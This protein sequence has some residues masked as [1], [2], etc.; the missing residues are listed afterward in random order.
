MLDEVVANC[1]PAQVEI[2][3]H[4]W[5][6]R[7]ASGVTRRANSTLVLGDVDDRVRALRSASDFHT[8][9]DSPTRLLVSDASAPAWVRPHLEREGFRPD[10]ETLMLTGPVQPAAPSGRWRVEADDEVTDQWFAAFWAIEAGRRHAGREA[11]MRATLLRPSLPAS[12]ISLLDD[13]RVVSV[14]QV[15]I[16]RGIGCVQCLATDPDHRGRGAASEVIG[17]L[18]TEAS[19]LGAT[20]LLAA[21]METNAASRAT[22]ARAGFTE[23]HRY[24]YYERR[25]GAK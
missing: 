10:A 3:H 1:W 9:H 17:Q 5:R 22:F 13:D 24:R 11:V 25:S 8:A 7:A 15:V 6:H 18:A 2:T 21:V 20:A 23:R 12:F 19:R 4:R 14:G 16:D